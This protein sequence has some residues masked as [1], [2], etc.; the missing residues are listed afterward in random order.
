M[1]EADRRVLLTIEDSDE[2]FAAFKWVMKKLSLSYRIF[3]CVDGDDAFDFLYGNG[4]YTDRNAFP[5]PSVICLDLNLPGTDGREVLTQIK[6]DETLKQIPVVIFTTSNNP[7]DI[8]LCYQYGASGYII[9]P[10]DLDR[11]IASLSSFFKYWFETV[12]FP[13]TH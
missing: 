11:L 5:R 3:R 13:D 12:V 10:I 2:D 1:L 6:Q 7:R 8:E 4:K 9:K